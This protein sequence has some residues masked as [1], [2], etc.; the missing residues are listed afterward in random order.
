MHIKNSDTSIRMADRRL[1]HLYGI[2]AV[3]YLTMLASQNWACAVCLKPAETQRLSVDH[4]HTTGV[5]RGLLCALCNNFLGKLDS[6]PDI[7]NRL[8][9]YRLATVDVLEDTGAQ[10]QVD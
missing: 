2:G 6:D 5:V 4:C 3:E 1:R 7:A 9:A 8:E 10:L